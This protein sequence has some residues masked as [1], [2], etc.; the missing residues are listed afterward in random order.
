MK[1]LTIGILGAT[2]AAVIISRRSK[3]DSPDV[4]AEKIINQELRLNRMAD[5]ISDSII[6]F[7]QRMENRVFGKVS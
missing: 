3:V 5:A 7:K 2:A 4:A 6:K 1:K